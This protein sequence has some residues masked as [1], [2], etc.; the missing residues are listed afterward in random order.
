MYKDKELS[1]ITWSILDTSRNSR[2]QV[3]EFIEVFLHLLF[4]KAIDKLN[5]EDTLTKKDNSLWESL[6]THSDIKDYMLNNIIPSLIESNDKNIK[7]YFENAY[8]V[9]D[10]VPSEILKSIY[11]IVDNIK[12]EEMSN[13]ERYEFLEFFLDEVSK[14]STNKGYSVVYRTPKKLRDFITSILDIKDTDSIAD[15]TCGSGSLLL[16]ANFSIH[17]NFEAISTNNIYGSDI[18]RNAIKIAIMHSY[19]SGIKSIHLEQK[20]TLKYYQAN[21]TQ[22]NKIYGSIPLGIK[23]RPEDVSPEFSIQTRSADILFLESITSSLSELGTSAVIVPQSLLASSSSGH[24]EIRKKLIEQMNIEAIISLPVKF[25]STHIPLFLII[26]KNETNNNPVL[27]IDLNSNVVNKKDNKFIDERLKFGV[28]LYYKYKDFNAHINIDSS[29]EHHKLYW[30]VEKESIA[31][32]EYILD[33][34]FYRPEVKKE[35]IAIE[36]VLEIMH[37]QLS[38]MINEIQNIKNLTSKIQTIDSS[39]FIE[40]KIGDICPDIRGG[41]PLP[42]NLEIENG[43]IPWIQ[44]RDITKSNVFEITRA[45]QN[46]SYEYALANH[47]TIVEPGAVILSVRGTLGTT[48]IAGTRICIGPNIVAL[49]ID[50]NKLNPWF[51]LGWFLKKKQSFENNVQAGIPT[52]TM[53]MLR[54]LTVN[55]PLL[56]DQEHFVNYTKAMQKLQNIKELS[57]DNNFQINTMADS[58]FNQFF[59]Q[60]D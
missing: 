12:L 44:I 4:V 17:K 28:E 19:I 5:I 6:L 47:L 7:Y 22:Y 16:S 45:E 49:N 29:D 43:E 14:I 54:N 13:R 8:S 20:D 33:I 24:I 59:N 11:D 23:V 31:D 26:F 58:I 40:E 41:R 51:L 1:R 52:I 57:Q 55:I 18:D 35:E 48:A 34:N 25:E 10:Y 32:N 9:F 53:S 3:S 36:N 30:F 42:R 37:V 21:C 38:S 46:I 15:F 50:K 60:K 27:F 39:K 56:E 2:I